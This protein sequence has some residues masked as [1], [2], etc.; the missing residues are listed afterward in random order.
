[1]YMEIRVSDFSIGD[2][3]NCTVHSSTTVSVWDSF[4]QDTSGF[5]VFGQGYIDSTSFIQ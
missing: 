2:Q 5:G 1:M 4:S 3:R